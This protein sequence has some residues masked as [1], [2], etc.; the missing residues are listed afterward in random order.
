MTMFEVGK[1][2]DESLVQFLSE[3]DK[4]VPEEEIQ[5]EARRYFDHAINLRKLIHFLRH[6]PALKLS[7]NPLSSDSSGLGVDLLR[8]ESLRGLDRATL[9][10]VLLKNYA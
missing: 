2:T 1:L 4:V 3:L 10:R 7:A 5:G 9:N 8:C 6:N